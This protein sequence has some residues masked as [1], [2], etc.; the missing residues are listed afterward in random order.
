MQR[1]AF[2]RPYISRTYRSSLKLKLISYFKRKI[3]FKHLLYLVF[4]LALVSSCNRDNRDDSVIIT[5]VIDE[6][7]IVNNGS[8]FGKVIDENLDPISDV[9]ITSSESIQLS[10][11]F[12]FFQFNNERFNKLGSWII[13]EKPGYFQSSKKIFSI[14]NTTDNISLT[15]IKKDAPWSINSN[16]NTSVNTVDNVM[17]EFPDDAFQTTDGQSYNGEVL[18]YSKW[19]DAKSEDFFDLMPGSLSGINMEQQEVGINSLGV[20]IME[21]ESTNGEKLFLKENKE[22]TVSIPTS[23]IQT[24]ISPAS[25]SIWLS[26]NDFDFWIESEEALLKGDAYEITLSNIQNITIGE[27]YEQVYVY[28]KLVS[29]DITLEKKSVPSTKVII[30]DDQDV[31]LTFDFTD[32]EGNFSALVPRNEINKIHT[33]DQC[34]NRI[35]VQDVMS[36][37]IE[38]NLGEVVVEINSNTT[39]IIGSVF[40][41]NGIALSN[42]VCLIENGAQTIAIKLGKAEDFSLN[43]LDCSDEDLSFRF[44]NLNNYEESD[45]FQKPRETYINCNDITICDQKRQ[46]TISFLINGQPYNFNQIEVTED[47]ANDVVFVRIPQVGDP[48]NSYVEMRL[49]LER[50]TYTSEDFLQLIQIDNSENAD[51]SDDPLFYSAICLDQDVHCDVSLVITKVEDH[52]LEGN[53]IGNIDF[54]VQYQNNVVENEN[55]NISCTFSISR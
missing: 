20:L 17:L 10:D 38:E 28:G 22:V 34:N 13:A 31:P 8:L 39:S 45:A 43:I 1:I 30:T 24:V 33:Y 37:D 27:G 36:F 4:L 2:S 53:F 29:N 42:V 52:L 19:I 35:N 46:S 50:G 16:Q 55:H 7:E 23:T 25:N 51:F 6:P 5:E 44:L 12:G 21:V 3:V 32:N 11:E 9:R 41:C 26:P 14:G 48:D 15:L 47:I 18:F 40:D 49:P 54:E